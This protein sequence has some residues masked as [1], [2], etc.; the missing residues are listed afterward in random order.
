MEMN[1][2]RYGPLLML[3]VMTVLLLISYIGKTVSY[4]SDTESKVNHAVMG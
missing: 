1:R 3:L 2:K 4:Y